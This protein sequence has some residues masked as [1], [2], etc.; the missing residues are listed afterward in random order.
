MKDTKVFCLGFAKTGTNTLTQMLEPMGYRVAGYDQFRHFSKADVVTRDALLAHALEV[1]KDYDASQDSPW[2]IFYREMDAAFPGSKFIHVIRD[3]QRWLDSATNDFG[4]HPNPVRVPI[5]G[6]DRPDGNE[7]G[8]LDRY[9]THNAE[10]AAY[11]ADRPDDYL[12]MKLEGG[13]NYKAVCDFLGE[14]Y[15]GQKVPHAN[16]RFSKGLRKIW[17]RVRGAFG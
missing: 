16:T 3:S 9:E 4:G 6:S 2:P 7:I 13:I 14:P 15:K 1:M 8:W 10:V 17:W 12:Q 11:F 5:Y